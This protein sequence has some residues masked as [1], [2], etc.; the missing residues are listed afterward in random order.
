MINISRSGP[1]FFPLHRH[2]CL[3]VGVLFLPLDGKVSDDLL[4]EVGSRKSSNNWNVV[5]VVVCLVLN[6]VLH[7]V[8]LKQPDL[9]VLDLRVLDLQMLDL[10]VSSHA[11][12]VFTLLF[13]Y[14][15]SY[16]LFACSCDFEYFRYYWVL[17]RD[18]SRLKSDFVV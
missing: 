17:N 13:F 12:V 4:L 2:V 3:G 10:L 1:I 8:V 16:C 5:V 18:V 11:V 15:T 7:Q 6:L 9:L 14:S